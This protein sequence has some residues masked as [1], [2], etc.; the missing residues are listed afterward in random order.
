M[1]KANDDGSL[2]V[3]IIGYVLI[4]AVLVVV[5]VDVSKAF[6]AQRSLSSAADAAALAGAQAVDRSA[7]YRGDSDCSDLPL[8]VGA[9]IAAVDASLDD[10]GDGLRQ[11][12]ATVSDPDVRVD[13]GIVHVRMRGEITV[14]FGNVLALLLPDNHPDERVGVTAEAA[15]TSV[16]SSP[17]C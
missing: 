16:L 14:P 3:L 1:L 4:A 11:T 13:G 2:T 7:I 12:F 6:L 10:A 8:D 9:A 15:A 5:G 17:S